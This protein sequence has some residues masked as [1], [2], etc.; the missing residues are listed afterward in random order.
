MRINKIKILTDFKQSKPN[1]N[2][3]QIKNNKIVVIEQKIVRR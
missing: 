2:K 1:I 3:L